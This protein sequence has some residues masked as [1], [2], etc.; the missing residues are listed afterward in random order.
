[1]KKWW[2]L[3]YARKE[4]IDQ[5]SK[6]NRYVVCSR[7]TKRPIF[8][9]VDTR[10]RPSD[11]LAVFAL[12]DDYSFGIL[13][14]ST[15]WD[16]FIARCSSLNGDSRY[17]SD[18]VFDSFCWPQAPAKKAVLQVAEAAAR[19]RKLRDH[20]LA[21]HGWSL[22]DLYRTLEEPG[23]N[24]L[25]S[26]TAELDEAVRAAYGMDVS[27][28]PLEFLLDLNKRCAGLEESGKPIVGPGI[29]PGIARKEVT[30]ST[31]CIEP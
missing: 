29:P 19:L 11:A 1:L 18:T 2:L 9:F 20:I 12:D 26:A 23:D 22:R 21:D 13:Q 24:P 25:R 5:L 14:S 17:T 16:W 7:V 27:A 10:I 6:L 4:M 30:L 28:D 3:S 15:H 8:A 31:D